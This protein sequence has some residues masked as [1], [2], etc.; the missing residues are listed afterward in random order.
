MQRFD[1]AH[2]GERQLVVGPVALRDDRYLV[3]TRTLERQIVVRGEVL[4]HGERTFRG[5]DEAF[6]EGHAVS[7]LPLLRIEV[8]THAARLHALV[9]IADCNFLM[10]DLRRDRGLPG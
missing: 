3:V 6:E 8:E 9:A 10:S 7:I 1:L 4:D 2:P 5:I